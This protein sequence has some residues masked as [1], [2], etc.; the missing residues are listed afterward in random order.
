MKMSIRINE[1]MWKKIVAKVR[2]GSK[3]A[4]KGQWSARKAQLAVKL[5]KKAGGKYKSKKSRKNSLVKWTTQKWTTKSGKNSILGK[6]AT[7]E[8]YLP[9]KIIKKL[10]KKEY[11]ATTRAKRKAK[12]QYSRQPFNISRKIYRKL[13]RLV[14]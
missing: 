1:K 12:K 8:R 13:K 9:S 10:T 3:G 4:R 7:G 6:N 2:A 11:T 14:G 5:Y